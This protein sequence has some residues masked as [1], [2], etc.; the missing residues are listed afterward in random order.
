[1][2][3]RPIILGWDGSDQARDA[4]TWAA[5][6]AARLHRPLTIVFALRV[7]ETMFAAEMAIITL[8]APQEVAEATLAEAQAL[9]AEI[10]PEVSTTVEW[11]EGHPVDVLVERSKGAEFLVLGSRGYSRL[12]SMIIG[13][14]GVAVTSHATCPVVV[15]RH[16]GASGDSA[17]VVVG[18]DGSRS[19]ADAIRFAAR[20][21][22]TMGV[23]LEVVGAV[24]R[25]T[26]IMAV[27][28]PVPVQVL[29]EA[30]EEATLFVH[31]ALGG[32][33][34]DYPDLHVSVRI[35][36]KPPV[37][38]L[39]EAAARARLL[40]VGSRGLGGF[41]GMLLGSVSRSVLFSAPCPVAVVRAAADVDKA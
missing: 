41:A 22:D 35:A 21:A 1:M 36:D 40:V 3:N 17:P 26:E 28:V 24:P 14:T 33:R 37:P 38:A 5:T 15:V 31:E 8:P 29:N 12:T 34:E 27:D 13:S 32:L 9:A 20:A 39:T 2:S 11:A 18:T 23:S 10:A 7:S 30:R 25:L 4:L 16:K 19:S 6:A